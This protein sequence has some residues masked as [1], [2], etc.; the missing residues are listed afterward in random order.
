MPKTNPRVMGESDED[1][2]GDSMGVDTA[3]TNAGS[4]TTTPATTK[5]IITTVTKPDT[6]KRVLMPIGKPAVKAP[7]VNK[8]PVLQESTPD[9]IKIINEADGTSASGNKAQETQQSTDQRPRR[10]SSQP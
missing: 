2:E 9:D 6:V 3:Q 4:A 5:G 10:A 8:T 7:A 1:E